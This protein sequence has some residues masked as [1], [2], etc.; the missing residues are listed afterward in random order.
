MVIR[1]FITAAVVG[2]LISWIHQLLGFRGR[3]DSHRS[4]SLFWGIGA[5]VLHATALAVFWVTFKTPP[6]VGFGPAA[7]TLAMALVVGLFLVARTSDRSSAGLLVLPLVLVFLAASAWVGPVP[8]QPTSELHGS[9]LVA[10]VVSVLAGYASLLLG[11]VAAAMYWL[12]FRALKQKEFGNVFRYFPSLESLDR[13]NQIGV[14]VG[15]S[16]LAIGLL[17]GWSLTLTYG[18]G[19]AFGDP[20]V[21]FGLLTWTAYAVALGVRWYSGGFGP[22]AARVSM[23]A[24]LASAT[25]FLALRSMGPT[26]EF[27]L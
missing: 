22:R 21:G 27:F 19:L 20:D 3:G 9:W 24:F 16:V 23:M 2:Y 25:G 1:L 5:A 11:S 18:R 26:T 6:L 8:A 13:M 14:G 12:Q 17:A 15:L 4:R 7:A 10:H